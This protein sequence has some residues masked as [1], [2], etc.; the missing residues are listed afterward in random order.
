MLLSF[1]SSFCETSRGWPEVQTVSAAWTG[2]LKYLL[3]KRSVEHSIYFPGKLLSETSM[4]VHNY[5][6]SFSWHKV[7]SIMP[8]P[9]CLPTLK[10]VLTLELTLCLF[11]KKY[12]W[13]TNSQVCLADKGENLAGLLIPQE[14]YFHPIL[15]YYRHF[16][17]IL[18][19]YK[20][21]IAYKG[22]VPFTATWW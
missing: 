16:H 17:P 14:E 6:H 11:C 9:P 18:E 3:Q 1:P 22:A 12:R 21:F 19:Y 7:F 8:C 2:V 15:E 13:S 10:M 20:A 4:W 5:C